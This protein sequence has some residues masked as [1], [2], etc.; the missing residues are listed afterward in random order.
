MGNIYSRDE[1]K[2][3]NE[4]IGGDQGGPHGSRGFANDT[5]MKDSLLGKLIKGIFTPLG[6]LIKKGVDNFV[7]SKL[8]SQLINE[9]LRGVFL[10]CIDKKIDLTTGKIVTGEGQ[11]E[12]TGTTTASSST[13]STTSSTTDSTVENDRDIEEINDCK[14][15]EEV[16]KIKD[17]WT[18][19]LNKNN[20][21]YNYLLTSAIGNL[22][23]AKRKYSEEK[24]EKE[25]EKIKIEI[26]DW[27]N[28][29][30]LR[31]I[32]VKKAKDMIALC[33]KRLLEMTGKN[34][35][36]DGV[37]DQDHINKLK[38]YIKGFN[39]IESY[40]S[41]TI[42]N[43]ID[44]PTVNKFKSVDVNKI[45]N[46]TIDILIA[47]RS[48][49]V[50][51][52]KQYDNL[53]DESKK[54]ILNT[55]KEYLVIC[56]IRDDL[57]P[58]KN[59][60]TLYEVTK[61]YTG[62]V[63]QKTGSE[64]L[65]RAPEAGVVGFKRKAALNTGVSPTVG[66]VLTTR[67]KK[68][69]KGEGE[70]VP[71]V[72]NIKIKN[73]N[74]AEIAK[75]FKNMGKVNVSGKETIPDGRVGASKYVNPYNLKMIVLTANHW[76]NKQN[77]E[78]SA[79]TDNNFKFKWEREITRV[80][81]TFEDLLDVPSVDILTQKF[82]TLDTTK[83]GKKEEANIKNIQET[84]EIA[85]FQSNFSLEDENPILSKISNNS[86][87]LFSF[88]FNNELLIVPAQAIETNTKYNLF[89]LTKGV[90]Y[91]NSLKD[92]PKFAKIFQ[93]KTINNTPSGLNI[94]SIK[95]WFSMRSTSSLNKKTDGQPFN[96]LVFNEFTMNDGKVQLCIYDKTGN[97]TTLTD[98][99]IKNYKS[100]K[101]LINLYLYSILEFLEL[102]DNDKRFMLLG[103]KESQLIKNNK[104]KIEKLTLIK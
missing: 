62:N 59:E 16:Q 54:K 78:G 41:E 10:F 27:T 15:P 45:Y 101:Y 38:S 1:F 53:N 55:T 75:T 92:D 25:K 36:Y 82:E 64:R 97:N 51:N 69:I 31:S 19:Q 104:D 93:T 39:P 11:I 103:E 4:L 30:K 61:I 58:V 24:N 21:G 2:K 52:S 35:E 70:E 102:T 96:I 86:C 67:D 80:N 99:F 94:R 83:V 3:L 37:G 84:T 47:M 44:Y 60:S 12:T 26:D 42:N 5:K 8:A 33:D 88:K 43:F 72:E 65:D 57:K 66:D 29:I 34:Y 28:K 90:A 85:K 23:A 81:S 100:D 63:K 46:S 18:E 17:E 68:K 9:L 91:S 95:T 77:K 87:Y 73:V 48:F 76:I 89:N 50:K 14:T 7:I 98:D 20:G 49:L 56:A 79:V 6:K 74:L 22:R 40:K 71:D 32:D 13:G